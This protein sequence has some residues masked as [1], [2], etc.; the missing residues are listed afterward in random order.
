MRT[1]SDI[2]SRIA[3]NTDVVADRNPNAQ[4]ITRSPFGEGA[5]VAVTAWSPTA[6]R[7]RIYFVQ[8]DRPQPLN[9]VEV[10]GLQSPY[11]VASF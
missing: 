8:P 9:W 2:D 11:A 3:T 1:N 10:T 5:G 4:A 6:S 7:Q